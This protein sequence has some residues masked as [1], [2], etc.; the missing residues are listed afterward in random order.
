LIQLAQNTLGVLR[1]RRFADYAKT[2][3]AIGDFDAEM[4]LDLANILV[5]RTA[6]LG[7]PTVIDGREAELDGLGFCW[8]LAWERW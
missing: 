5:P 6:E 3:A 2:I 7:E 8:Q 1:L 4:V